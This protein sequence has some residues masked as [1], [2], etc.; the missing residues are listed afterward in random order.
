MFVKHLIKCPLSQHLKKGFELDLWPTNLNINRD[1]YSK[2]MINRLK[3]L[4]Q[5]VLELSI[6]Q[7]VVDT[8]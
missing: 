5:R 3:I 1:L 2:R 4:V 7:G 6:A 8:D